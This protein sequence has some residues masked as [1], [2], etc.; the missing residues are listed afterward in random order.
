MFKTAATRIAHNSTL[1]ALGG[2][3]DLKPLQDLITAEKGIVQ[4]LAKLSADFVKASEA[5]RNWGVGEGDDLGDTLNAST[6]ILSHFSSALLKFASHEQA[7]RDHMKAVRSRE[8][9]LD[10]LRHRKKSMMSKADSAE[11]KLNKM[12]PEHKNLHAQTE[13][14]NRLQDEIRQLDSEI[15]TEEASLGDFKRS[16]T[17]T[18]MTLKFGGL[19]ECCEKGV[20][21]GDAGKV[22]IAEIPQD[23][24]LP[25][26]PRA[27]YTGQPRTDAAVQNAQRAVADV[28]FS[29]TPLF[30]GSNPRQRSRDYTSDTGSYTEPNTYPE[31]GSF[32]SRLMGMGGSRRYSQQQLSPSVPYGG[33]PLALQAPETQGGGHF[34]TFPVKGAGPTHLSNA[35]SKDASFSSE[36]ASA[37]GQ[38][39]GTNDLVSQ[40][41]KIPYDEPAPKYEPVATSDSVLPVSGIPVN[42]EG[43]MANDGNQN[44]EEESQLPWAEPSENP[45]SGPP[46]TER[47]VRFGSRP[48]EIGAR[49]LTVVNDE[50]P[51]ASEDNIP[52]QRQSSPPKSSPNRQSS[53]PPPESDPDDE[54]ALNAAAAREVSRELDSLNFNS[55][56]S[57]PPPPPPVI[58]PTLAPLTIPPASDEPSSPRNS[59]GS[60]HPISPYTRERERDSTS[61]SS[62]RSPPQNLSPRLSNA[63][64]H[65]PASRGRS[66]S[67]PLPVPPSIALSPS[68]SPPKLPYAPTPY[69]T[70]Q[71][72]PSLGVGLPSTMS[73]PPSI[74]GSSPVMSPAAS[75][76]STSVNVPPPGGVR[77]ISA[78][79]FRRPV[80]RLASDGSI[81]GMANVADTS[82]LA[83]KKRG[84][85]SSPYA[86][87]GAGSIGG[88]SY[89]SNSPVPPRSQI[90]PP[91]P[92]PGGTQPPRGTSS[93]GL[94]DDD[95]FDYISAYVNSESTDDG[96]QRRSDGLR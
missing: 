92:L 89:S 48:V 1:P 16:S 70:P 32:G 52:T 45:W 78:A 69:R 13:S 23:V 18:W 81:S 17:K 24:T 62:L 84:L 7:M 3:K 50:P 80:N 67:Q 57:P 41:P 19:Q 53:P 34:A 44:G 85:P 79:A 27:F 72:S 55:F 94:G 4:S 95:Q 22:I 76:S 43:A 58:S 10:A 91:P 5:L 9:N 2:N 90:P 93:P 14:L 21:V 42:S 68:T 35:I 54:R 38:S 87:R 96:G 73:P 39:S 71:E 11:K 75:H 20:I 74:I 64:P 15:M 46:Q 26:S 12:S 63:S 51:R 25:G 77:T 66:P 30:E 61:N 65:M 6:L 28:V 86:T 29:A 33:E 83:L 37:L 88:G 31:S 59:I 56:G 60:P 47:R 82:P 8:E 49:P 36:V 40:T